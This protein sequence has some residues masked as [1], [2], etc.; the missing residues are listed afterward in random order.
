MGGV[1]RRHQRLGR[2]DH[3][4]NKFIPELT[5][6]LPQPDGWDKVD[7]IHAVLDRFPVYKPIIA[8][9]NG[10]CV[11]GGFEMLGSADIRARRVLRRACG[12]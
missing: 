5:G 1:P 9:V 3:D 8:A 11:A 7:A 6:E 4:L 12:G 2:G 10:T